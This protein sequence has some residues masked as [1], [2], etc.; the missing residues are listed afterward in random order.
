MNKL[1]NKT[2]VLKYVPS[3]LICSVITIDGLI[4]AELCKSPN[5]LINGQCLCEVFQLHPLYL[6]FFNIF[7][8]IFC[9]WYTTSPPMLK[10]LS[11]SIF[12]TNFLVQKLCKSKYVFL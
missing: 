9:R 6:S 8:F 3:V 12:Q 2:I 10:R 5:Y 7:T 4:S 1:T 11:P